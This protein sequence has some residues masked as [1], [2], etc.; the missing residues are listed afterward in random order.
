MRDV[1]VVR[2]EQLYPFPEA[3][4]AAVIRRNIPTPREVVWCQEEPQNQGGWY[5][6]RHH[7]QS[8]S[9]KEHQLLYAGRAPARCAGDGHSVRCTPSSSAN[10]WRQRC[11][12]SHTEEALRQT[13]RLKAARQGRLE[14]A[15]MLRN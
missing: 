15:S 2:I 10:W 1:A 12:R 5:Q 7:L 13:T 11:V 14:P 3:D 6:I 4:Y 9:P 8:R